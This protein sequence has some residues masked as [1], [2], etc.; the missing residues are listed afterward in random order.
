M[1]YADQEKH[2]QVSDTHRK[3]PPGMPARFFLQYLLKRFIP[4]D[5]E[6]G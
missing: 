6:N 2:Q 1:P 4:L 3:H 5:R